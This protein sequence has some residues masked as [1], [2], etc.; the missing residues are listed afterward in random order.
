MIKPARVGFDLRA[1][2][3]GLEIVFNL[4]FLADIGLNFVTAIRVRGH[5]EVRRGV[6]AREYARFWFW[7]DLLASFPFDI[8]FMDGSAAD[9]AT[10]SEAGQN[11]R[12]NK[13]FRMLR[14]FK[15]LT[16]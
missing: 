16:D 8:I 7:V 4:F 13:L 5:L 1:F 6:I 9:T 10:S 11:L 12:L 2:S 14:V 3:D 15:V